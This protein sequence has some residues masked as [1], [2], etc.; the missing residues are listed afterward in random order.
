[1]NQGPFHRPH[2]AYTE[3]LGAAQPLRRPSRTP[4][5][6]LCQQRAFSAPQGVWDDTGQQRFPIRA[7]IQRGS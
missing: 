4:A 3:R 1:M 2:Q 6:S 5:L 7:Q